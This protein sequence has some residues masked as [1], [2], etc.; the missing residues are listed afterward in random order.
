[1]TVQR[2]LL[3][4]DDPRSREILT[5]SLQGQGYNLLATASAEEGLERIGMEHPDLVVCNLRTS[6]LSTAEFSI[7]LHNRYCDLPQLLIV[8]RAAEDEALTAI[9]D[10]TAE[11]LLTPTSTKS[12]LAAVMRVARS[13][14][15]NQEAAYLRGQACSVEA[16]PFVV[17]SDSLRDV[18]RSAARIARV[19]GPVLITGETGSGKGR[20]AEYI[21]QASFQAGHAFI[22][23]DCTAFGPA[24]LESELFGHERCLESGVSRQRAGCFE[25]AEG[26]TLLL[27]EVG[28]L[29]PRIQARL[30]RVLKCGEYERVGGTGTLVTN[31]RI[32][33]TSSRDLPAAIAAEEYREDLYYNLH[34]H[35]LH[36]APLRERPMDILPQAYQ[37]AL[38]HSLR[39]SLPE[40]EFSA[41]FE[42][43]LLS[44]PW[45]GNTRELEQVVGLAASA[46]N[47]STL[48]EEH[49]PQTGDGCATGELDLEDTRVAAALANQTMADIERVAILA[50]LDC[51]RGNKTEAARRL[52]LTART[53]SNKM[54]IW[55]QAGLVA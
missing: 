1:M 28:V 38:S 4:D 33:T 51:S 32:I 24:S 2:I 22:R 25:L 31:A 52:G 16:P 26:G 53:L 11:V 15:Q 5:T 48:L 55:R 14:K 46:A 18:L 50:T 21:H 3:I 19:P 45:L 29:P 49:L 8:P 40:P 30:L 36:I 6:S 34:T 41:E 17:E 44:A 9:K 35:P 43:W 10:R 20:L 39:H 7:R 42:H 54:K 13:H 47:G 23:I 37:V 12:V 27:E